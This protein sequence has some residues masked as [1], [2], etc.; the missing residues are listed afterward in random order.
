MPEPI[1]QPPMTPAEAQVF[2]EGYAV[3]QLG[4]SPEICEYDR[5]SYEYTLWLRGYV[6]GMNDLPTSPIG[7]TGKQG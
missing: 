2:M 1:K 6:E 3:A 4:E 5:M 7:R